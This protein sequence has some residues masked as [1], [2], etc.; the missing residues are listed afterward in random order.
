[1]LTTAIRRWYVGSFTTVNFLKRT[2]VFIL[3]FKNEF[4]IIK[5]YFLFDDECRFWINFELAIVG[6]VLFLFF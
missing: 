2:F 5:L 3:P 6:I 1:M 4:F